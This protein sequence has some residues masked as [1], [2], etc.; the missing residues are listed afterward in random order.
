MRDLSLH[1]HHKHEC[2][3]SFEKNFKNLKIQII[4]EYFINIY[5]L[6]PYGNIHP[7]FVFVCPVVKT[8]R[9]TNTQFS[10]LKFEHERMK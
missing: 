5:K 10:N 2:I 3:K 4:F 1:M 7:A 6:F 9:H 8:D